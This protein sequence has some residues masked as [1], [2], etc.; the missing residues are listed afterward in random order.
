[1]VISV[2]E[3]T[4]L[5]IFTSSSQRHLISL[6]ERLPIFL[7]LKILSCLDNQWTGLIRLYCVY[8]IVSLCYSYCGSCLTKSVI[9]FSDLLLYRS[10]EIT[11]ALNYT[12]IIGEKQDL[13]KTRSRSFA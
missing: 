9:Y 11:Y 8:T 7:L 10:L 2:Q 5:N 6:F 3:M 1:M 4:N 13:K 12:L